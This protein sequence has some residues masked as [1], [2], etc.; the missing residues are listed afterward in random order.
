MIRNLRPLIPKFITTYQHHQN[1]H[2]KV[3]GFCLVLRFKLI[4]E[5]LTLGS[6][7][8]SKKSF[9]IL[10]P[11]IPVRLITPDLEPGHATIEAEARE[12][13]SL[14]R[15]VRDDSKISRTRPGRVFDVC[16]VAET[17]AGVRAGTDANAIKLRQSGTLEMFWC[18]LLGCVALC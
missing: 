8:Y 7:N 9:T 15:P 6:G 4:T 13:G 16:D 5:F 2:D 17:R 14:E 1:E 3:V 11:A 10:V 12:A 18:P